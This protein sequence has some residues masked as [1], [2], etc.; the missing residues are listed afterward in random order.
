MLKN[1]S[2]D[3]LR[4][5]NFR[6]LLA[7]RSF[8]SMTI[9]SLGTIIAWQVY[10][11]T[12]EPFMVGLLGLVEAVPAI[13]GALYAGHIVDTGRPLTIFRL[14]LLLLLANTL[15]FLLY[16][17][18]LIDVTKNHLV[19]ILF[20]AT[21]ASGLVRSLFPPS[22]FAL[23]SQIVARAQ[24]PQ[25]SAWN[26]SGFRLASI[27][28]PAVAGFIYAQYDAAGAWY[29][30]VVLTGL[31]F[32]FALNVRLPPHP[33][34]PIHQ[35]TALKSIRAGLHFI[36]THP[37]MMSMMTLDMFAVLLGG[38]TAMLPA[39]A[40]RVLHTGAESLGLLRAAP[41]AGALVTALIMAVSQIKI[42][43]GR[44]LLYAVAGF[45][46]CMIG[47]GMS[48][49]LPSAMIF[50][51][52][53]G[54]FDSISVNF[55]STMMQILTPDTMRGRVSSIN[56]MFIISS[57]EIGEFESGLTAHLMGLIPSIVAGGVGSLLVVAAV[58]VMSPTFRKTV[59]KV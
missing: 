12:K 29:L 30:P 46:L 53:S 25:A 20:A 16:G 58:A 17:G 22:S 45:G 11:L 10:S 43:S 14:G 2:L 59:I 24:L 9:T 5:P 7:A 33:K 49:T 37:V 6:N 56:S 52:L 35:E 57:N 39:F 13:A 21:F 34:A 18:G 3:V 1:P 19:I 44:R 32:L 23:L 40:D 50:L 48:T 8:F 27:C 4:I 41:A 55:R 15:I 51:A 42:L 28:G 36:T 26:T 31:S 54:V 47:F 38:A